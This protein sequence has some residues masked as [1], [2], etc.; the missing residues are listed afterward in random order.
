MDGTIQH[1]R[2][3]HQLGPVTSRAGL[4]EAF[5]LSRL[6]HQELTVPERELKILLEDEPKF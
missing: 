4:S 2:V 3:T 5:D 1:K 6:R